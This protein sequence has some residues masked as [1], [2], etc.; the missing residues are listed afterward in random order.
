[1]KLART[2]PMALMASALREPSRQKL[3]LGQKQRSIVGTAALLAALILGASVISIE[4]GLSVAIVEIGLG[5]VAGNFFGLEVAPWIDFLAGFAG[6]TLTF[7]AGV[8]VDLPVMRTNLKQSLL[9]GGASFAL[10]FAAAFALCYWALGW[11]LP[12]A[13][14]GGAALSTTS[15]AVVYAVLVE[16]GLSGTRLGKLLMA[17]TFVTD[18]GTAVALSLLFMRL[19]WFTAA[20]V[21]VAVAAIFLLPRTSRWF[22]R[23]YGGRV[24]EPETKLIFAMLFVLM[25][26]AERGESQAVLPAFIL[27]LAMSRL[28]EHHREQKGRLQVVAFALLT[29]FF[30]VKSGMSVSLDLVWANLGLLAVLL[31]TKTAAKFLGVFPLAHRYLRPNATYTTLLMSTGLTFGTI[32]SVYGLNAGYIDQTQFSLLVATVVASAVIPTLIAQRWFRPFF[33]PSKTKGNTVPASNP[34][35]EPCPNCGHAII[36]E[37]EGSA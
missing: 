20:F 6:I 11:S 34:G 23:R 27:G 36:A 16:T 37:S 18:F 28:Y 17:S 5:V 26:L 2:A 32:S 15:L 31:G 25:L 10:P 14:V 19:N 33:V 4:F 9:I 24:I 22:F 30:F 12:A 35:S 7:L 1:M 29:P 3:F 21:I 13:E 8:E